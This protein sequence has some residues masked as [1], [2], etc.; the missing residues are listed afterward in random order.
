MMP[1]LRIDSRLFWRYYCFISLTAALKVGNT[2]K[3]R[4]GKGSLYKEL[5][6][7]ESESD[8]G[9]DF[10]PSESESS[11]AISSQ[12]EESDEDDDDDEEFNP[13]RGSDSDEGRWGPRV[14]TVF[15]TL[16]KDVIC[17]GQGV[18]KTY[19]YTC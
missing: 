16:G 12:D 3:T 1:S 15:Q 6:D 4:S 2:R 18:V 17:L 5:S 10:E 11:E 13:F 14:S 7:E 9:S 19:K 8:S